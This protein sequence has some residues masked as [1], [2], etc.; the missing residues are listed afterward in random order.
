MYT[1][2]SFDNIIPFA[3]PVPGPVIA[4]DTAEPITP[5]KF[6][7]TLY[8][9]KRTNSVPLIVG[10]FPSANENATSKTTLSAAPKADLAKRGATRGTR[11][12]ILPDGSLTFIGEF[13]A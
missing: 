13:C 12:R 3:A 2:T 9:F 10:T 1:K 4:P 8:K 5:T 7:Y 11:G 6:G